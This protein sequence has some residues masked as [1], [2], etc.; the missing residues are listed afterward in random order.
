MNVKRCEKIAKQRATVPGQPELVIKDDEILDF[1]MVQFTKAQAYGPWW[2]GRVIRNAFQVAMSLAY[3]ET[4]SDYHDH[5]AS[6][7]LPG[8]DDGRPRATKVFGKKHFED[9]RKIF[10]DFRSYRETLGGKADAELARSNEER[11]GG[12]SPTHDR[13]ASTHRNH[14]YSIRKHHTP[15]AN[16]QRFSQHL[17]RTIQDDRRRSEHGYTTASPK[18]RKPDKRPFSPFHAP[19]EIQ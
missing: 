2:N 3:V 4:A 14:G 6:T 19:R 9:V 8:S 11:N 5:Q 17:A 13:P 16:S 12:T 10:D 18:E 7:Q 15:S 1:A